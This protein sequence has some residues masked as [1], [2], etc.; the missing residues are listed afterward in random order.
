MQAECNFRL[1]ISQFALYQLICRQRTT[2][3]LSFKRV[4]PGCEPAEFGR[5]HR[6]PGNAIASLV[7]TTERTT[8]PFDIRQEVFFGHLNVVEDNFPG[9]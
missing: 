3:L 9:H 5:S 4:F 1:H 8:Q 6:T 7:Q 2:E